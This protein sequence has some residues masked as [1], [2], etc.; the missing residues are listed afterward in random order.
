DRIYPTRGERI[1]FDV[2]AADKSV[3]SNA[4][5]F[6]AIARGK[7]IQ[8][9]GE[10]RFRLIT[11]ADLGYTVTN[12]FHDLPP[13]V[14]FFAGG[15]QSVRGYSYQGIGP[16]D[17]LGRVLGGKALEVASAELE[18]RFLQKWGVAAFYDTGTANDKFGG[19]LKVGT[20]VGVRWMSPIGLIR[21]D[22]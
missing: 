20:G 11:R 3:L 22:V 6:Q 18:Y 19:Q 15:D 21:L 13:T 7:F 14:R 1:E 17:A 2:R 5:F 4:T 16:R 12:D 10:E 9:F 8:S